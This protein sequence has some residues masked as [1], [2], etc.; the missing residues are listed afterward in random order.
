MST[1]KDYTKIFEDAKKSYEEK[2]YTP[3][4]KFLFDS[5]NSIFK[6]DKT[7]PAYVKIL[8]CNQCNNC[9]AYKAGKCIEINNVCSNHCPFY[10]Q[11]YYE[12]VTRR[13]KSYFT[14]LNSA[15]QVFAI[16]SDIITRRL[17]RLNNT[18]P[19]GD[20]SYIYL[21]LDHLDNYV[22]PICK[23]LEIV[24]GNFIPTQ[25]FTP[26]VVQKLLEYRPQALFG[27]EITT[28]RESNLPQFVRDLRVYFPDL[29]NQV[30]KNTSYADIEHRIDFKG[31]KAILKTLKPGKVKFN[32]KT[33]EWNG[34]KL[35]I[36]GKAFDTTL[37]EDELIELTPKEN[38]VVEII[39]NDTVDELK[40]RF[41]EM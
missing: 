35:C 27:G 8:Y 29:Y 22:N 38:T 19:V 5:S 7:R 17:Y 20:G 30:V 14:F 10:K 39:D 31:K 18:S 21:H 34:E 33:W 32:Y 24:R 6:S 28:Y 15:R 12:G 26:E 23:E 40:T 2:G 16:S 37:E 25:N 1:T 41:R 3:I 4:Y 9:E 36:K 13:S 11:Y